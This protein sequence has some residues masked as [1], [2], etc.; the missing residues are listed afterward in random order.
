MFVRCLQVFA[1]LTFLA[2]VAGAPAQAFAHAGETHASSFGPVESARESAA[3][4]AEVKSYSLSV[5]YDQ[6]KETPHHRG[7]SGSCCACSGSGCQSAATL[8]AFAEDVAL[9]RA[10]PVAPYDAISPPRRA[11]TSLEHPPKS[12]A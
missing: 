7:C 12:F 9:T 2:L 6:S 11:Q 3:V 4:P 8:P 5:P 10:S 1:A